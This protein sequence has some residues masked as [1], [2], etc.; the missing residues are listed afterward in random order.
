MVSKKI[1]NLSINNLIS[2]TFTYGLGSGIQKIL[3]LILIFFISKELTVEEFG[4]FDFYLIFSNLI[5][6]ILVFGQDQAI[7][8][9]FYNF[10]S[11]NQRQKII[12]ES[13]FFQLFLS[14]IFLPLNIFLLNI[15]SSI[16]KINFYEIELG[17]AISF[18]IFLLIIFN[19]CINIL[20]WD[21]KKRLFIIGIVGNS[22]LSLTTVFYLKFSNSLNLIN[23]FYCYIFANL[24]LSF[25]LIIKIK[26]WIKFPKKIFYLKKIFKYGIPLG[27]ISILTSSLIFI[28]R[29][30]ILNYFTNFHLG[31]YAIAGKLSL[32]VF[33]FV[34]SFQ[35]SWGPFAFKSY[36]DKK[37]INKYNYI[38]KIFIFST[39]IILFSV[40][41]WSETLIK[42]LSSEKY[43]QAK[44][45]IFPL[46]LA[47]IILGLGNIINIGIKLAKRSELNLVSN[48]IFFICTILLFY[49]FTL[50]KYF[51]GIAWSI[52]LG[53]TILIIIEFYFAQKVYPM[54]WKIFKSIF[55]LLFFLIFFYFL[56]NYEFK[57]IN[58][59]LIYLLINFLMFLSFYW[60]IIRKKLYH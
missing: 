13:F 25:Y 19:F 28:E 6:M 52:V 8:R 57:T 38:V 7:A 60:I 21:F 47:F 4:I 59:I 17:I 3:N 44:N 54:K 31:I 41:F 43:L 32:I 35:L 16:Y 33:F 24:L 55:V 20:R 42:L 1:N 29:S 22:V 37:V 12:S 46:S 48:I 49:F 50:N 45:L 40:C 53:Q 14:I 39:T 30:V 58:K 34:Q 11:F 51:L 9:L 18:L 5:V 56:L 26:K 10:N 2:D 23:I 15:I 36:R 27:L